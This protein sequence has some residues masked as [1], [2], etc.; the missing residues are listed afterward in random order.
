MSS[1][2]LLQSAIREVN[3]GAELCV[4]VLPRSSRCMVAGVQDGCLKIKL[5]SPPVDGQA[6]A[7]CC[8]F[9]AKCA[10]V[11][12]TNVCIVRGHTSRRKVLLVR[13]TTLPVLLERLS[14]P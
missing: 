1:A 2:E 9:I 5:T 8:A 13:N 4:R 11:P 14:R 12:K 7:E 3:A 10:G 6:N